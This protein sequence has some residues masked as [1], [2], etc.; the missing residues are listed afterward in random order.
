MSLLAA[1]VRRS[2][3]VAQPIARQYAE[4]NMLAQVLIT[5][6]EEPVFD[7]YT[8]LTTVV[9]KETI[10]DGIARIYGVTGP[11]QYSVGEEPTYYSSTNISIPLASPKPRVDDLVLVVFH[12]DLGLVGRRFRVQDVEAGGQLPVVHRMQAVGIQSSKQWGA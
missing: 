8:G 9:P 3:L 6:G 11:V 1:I 7:S 12:L 10:W 2:T 4:G 5:R